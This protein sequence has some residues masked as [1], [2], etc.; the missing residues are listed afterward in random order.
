MT[1][2]YI[3]ASGR[4]AGGTL[5]AFDSRRRSLAQSDIPPL[6]VDFYFDLICPW[7]LI[8]K[9][10]LEAALAI[11]RGV[12]GNPLVQVHWHSVRLLPD[13]PLEGRDFE[14]FYLQRLGGVEPMRVRQAQVAK[15]ARSAGIELQMNR[16]RRLPNTLLAHRLL[17]YGK[18][19][20]SVE[21]LEALLDAMFAAYFQEGV[22]LGDEA[23][24][25]MV[26]SCVG[27]DPA[28]WKA[29][30]DARPAGLEL[31]TSVPLFVFNQSIA[32]SGAQPAERLLE[33]MAEA[34]AATS[35]SRHEEARH[36]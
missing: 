25:S 15:A 32:L 21:M 1:S 33:A 22:D 14:A 35:D 28:A 2:L 19:Q 4:T 5:P 23:S 36:R 11:F 29:W 10:H 12:P 9:K 6:N 24:L 8:G 3:P 17:A 30:M 20:L 27:L 13:T 31:A 18:E 16:I 34:L 7:C 26:C